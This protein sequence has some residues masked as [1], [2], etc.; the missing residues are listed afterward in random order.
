MSLTL[1]DIYESTKSK[2]RLNLITPL[3]T[4]KQVMNWVYIGEDITTFDYLN[5]GELV[6]TTGLC[7]HNSKEL[8]DFIHAL[9]QHE[10][11]GLIINIGGY[12]K[13]KNITSDIRQLC[14]KNDF[15][16]FTMPWEISFQAITKDY[17]NRIFEDNQ[18][19]TAITESFLSILRQDQDFENSILLLDDYQFTAPESY[20]MCVLNY[21]SS[22][23]EATTLSQ[24]EEWQ[25]QL[26]Y[27][28]DNLLHDDSLKYHVMIYKNTIVFICCDSDLQLIRKTMNQILSHLKIIR[29]R[30]DCRIGI[31]SLTHH[32]ADIAVSY[33]RA[34]AALT[35]AEYHK[36][37]LYTFEEMG[38]FRLLLSVHDQALLDSY[39]DE[40][41]GS[42]IAYDKQHRSNYL[43]TLYQYLLSDGSIQAIAAAMFCHRNTVNYRVRNLKEMLDCDLD[44]MK[45]RFNYMV[46]FCVKEYL[47]IL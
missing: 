36:L 4:L 2:Y 23:D 29:P 40:Y 21:R 22:I 13:P 1:Q 41:L 28:I 42:L 5:G 32:L 38:F 14:V 15:A 43:D 12:L 17:Y 9:I 33:K 11:C 35:M 46:A 39:L 25:K 8:Y 27:S 37:S 26:L 31:G 6:I 19:D 47:E 16:L 3:H 44:D 10:C 20:C 30:F 45:V 24:T 18:T 7:I 34:C